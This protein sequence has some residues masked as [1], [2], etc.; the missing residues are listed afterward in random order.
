MSRLVKGLAL[1]LLVWAVGPSV[2]GAEAVVPSESLLPATTKAFVSVTSVEDLEARWEQTQLG[3]LMRDPVMEPFAQ[4][5]RRQFQDRWS[6]I[7]EKLG[8]TLED[9]EGVPGGEV[10]AGLV[11]LDEAEWATLLLVDV[12]GHLEQASAALAKAAAAQIR[13]G[14]RRLSR[15]VRQTEVTVFVLPPKDGSKEGSN[16]PTMVA[17]FLRDD[18]LAAAD[19]LRAIEDILARMAGEG[20]PALAGWP[21]FR[22]VMGRCMEDAGGRVPQIRWWVEPFGYF[23]AIDKAAAQRERLIV[24]HRRTSLLDVLHQTG[25]DAV[26]GIGGTVEVAVDGYDFLHRTVVFAPP[27]YEGSMKMMVFPNQEEFA[28]PPWVPRD[29][30]TYGTGYCDILNVFDNF[31]PLFDRL[32]G[33]GEEGVWEDVLD[34]MK[35]DPNGPRIDLRGELFAHLGQRVTVVGNYKLPITTSSERLLFAIEALDESAV[36]A[37]IE[38]TLKDDPEMRR[39]KFGDFIIWE[40]VPPEERPTLS[41]SVEVPPLGPQQVPSPED[42]EEGEPLLPNAAIT[43]AYGHLMI[44]SHYDFLTEILTPSEPRAAL[45][46]SV[47]WMIVDQTLKKLGATHC[48]VRTFSR[49]AEEYRA[50]YELV[51]QGKLPQSETMLARALNTLLGEPKKGY[52]EPKVDGSQLPDYEYVRRYLGLAGLFIVSESD[53]W[54]VKGAFL[55]NEGL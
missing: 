32:F 38:K 43:V 30:A 52:R 24:R 39:R 12:T 46:D 5:L 2:P 10:A 36:A 51:R 29:V 16:Q 54:F 53:G 20:P 27:P 13:R 3:H 14:A 49:T 21:A 50:T 41:V 23:A 7:H 9:M 17:Y 28:P 19:D 25:F 37:A 1:G 8:L 35:N 18:L 42:F 4:D 33:E 47:D 22:A 34:G 15:T 44:A 55:P 40:A 11:Q 26:Q 48:C 45:R 31:G 6:K